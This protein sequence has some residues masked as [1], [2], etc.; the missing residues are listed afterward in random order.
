MF[1]IDVSKCRYPINICVFLPEVCSRHD[2]PHA[3]VFIFHVR[4][5]SDAMW[6]VHRHH[7]LIAIEADNSK[8]GDSLR[9]PKNHIQ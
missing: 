5:D 3:N 8:G 7:V 1:K 2:W 4:E 9:D 6:L